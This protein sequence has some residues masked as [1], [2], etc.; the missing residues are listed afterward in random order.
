MNEVFHK[1]ELK[2]F[3]AD[4]MVDKCAMCEDFFLYLDYSQR[5]G[6]FD[7][8]FG[9]QGFFSIKKSG[10]A[11][12]CDI[13]LCF[14]K[15]FCAISYSDGSL[16]IFD[17]K[18]GKL[19]KELKRNSNSMITILRYIDD[20]TIIGIDDSKKLVLFKISSGLFGISVNEVSLRQFE[21]MPL[22]LSTPP[23]YK[24]NSQSTITDCIA[25]NFRGFFVISLSNEFLI[26]SYIDSFKIIA[27]L[28]FH[29]AVPSIRLVDYQS[30]HI[31][32]AMNNEILVYSVES[33]GKTNLLHN[34]QISIV[35][36]FLSMISN[37]IV[38]LFD[39]KDNAQ[40]LMID[41]GKKIETQITSSGVF[42]SGNS[43]V[44]IISSNKFWCLTLFSF[45]ER[46]DLLKGLNDIEKVYELC[47]EAIIGSTYVAYDLPKSIE[48]R[49]IFVEKEITPILDTYIINKSRNLSQ[50]ESII[51][52]VVSYSY[53]LGLYYWVSNNGLQIFAQAKS[54]PLYFKKIIE[55]DPNAKLFYYSKIFVDLL[56]RYHDVI[57]VD[58]FLLS[59]QLESAD[60]IELL[61]YGQTYQKPCFIALIF[62][63]KLH[64]FYSSIL[65]HSSVSNWNQVFDEICELLSMK[66]ENVSKQK[67]IKW[68]LSFDGTGFPI[69][70]QLLNKFSDKMLP[71]LQNIYDMIQ[72]NDIECNL[73]SFINALLS[74][75]SVIRITPKQDLFRLIESI[76]INNVVSL[77]KISFQYV[78][79][80]VFIPQYANNDQRE[81]TL[82]SILT[83]DS[84]KQFLEGLLP[85]FDIYKF[86][87]ARRFVLMQI[88]DYSNVIKDIIFDKEEPYAFIRKLLRLGGP[89]HDKVIQS[90]KNNSDSLIQ[91]NLQKTLNFL[92][93][94]IPE[95]IN[96]IISTFSNNDNRNEYLLE[97]VFKENMVV[98]LDIDYQLSLYKYIFVNYP[99][100][101]RKL[102]DLYPCINDELM[103]YANEAKL[104]DMC[105]LLTSKRSN[106]L[107]F[108]IQYLRKSF[109]CSELITAFSC[110]FQ[111][112]LD[113]LKD[114]ITDPNE[115]KGFAISFFRSYSIVF[116]FISNGN[117]LYDLSILHRF[118]DVFV[119]AMPMNPLFISTCSVIKE[120]LDYRANSAFTSAFSLTLSKFETEDCLIQSFRE[121]QSSYGES[122]ELLKNKQDTMN[123]FKEG[124]FAEFSTN[125]AIDQVIEEEVDKSEVKVSEME[126][127][128]V[129]EGEN[130]SEVKVSEMESN[131]VIQGEDKSEVKVSEMESNL[132]IEEEDKSEVKVSEMESNLVI[133]GENKSEVKVSEMESNLVIQGEDKSEVKVSEMESNLVIE[134]EYKSEVKVSEMESNLVIQ[135][136]DKSE[137][138]VSEM[139]SNPVIEEEDKSEVKVSEMES[140]PVI[141]EEEDKSDSRRA[142][143]SPS[144]Q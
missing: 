126:S 16:I 8:I 27:Q 29:A 36:T 116:F 55:T 118:L 62:K 97:L 132:V 85:L 94:H 109:S 18:K 119:K 3:F 65:T 83:S 51:H 33:S 76:L 64:D 37:D 101:S 5:V 13:S 135:G 105:F 122:T 69:L 11:S 52:Q 38:I 19:A 28:P 68:I 44:Y 87:Q 32:L 31:T 121:L 35:P 30:I 71:I 127:N 143:I 70:K 129:I 84:P 6:F 88:R 120:G 40:V 56:I 111:N 113:Q 81:A 89:S 45:S 124:Y 91:Y 72:N 75:F 79:T 47:R 67:V 43:S 107:V 100:L 7:S 57:N 110:D 54:L 117:V 74:V 77:G 25:P 15:L 112:F 20:S 59:L 130:K 61:K 58:D 90:I 114:M 53:E 138:K 131:L 103:H 96:S 104:F 24:S 128:L 102:Y 93:K 98:P 49:K 23:I 78:L 22:Y 141:E 10:N 140:N 50:I 125:K 63:K 60:P 106:K 108:F 99:K 95:L 26:C 139:E 136:E 34:H 21:G 42:V 82:L 17:I 48:F 9:T 14:N 92:K 12:P 41:E 134:E 137:V 4:T 73:D 80:Q 133:E 46:I 1:K 39:S 115:M 2:G 86:P 144:Y 142:G 66:N 123:T